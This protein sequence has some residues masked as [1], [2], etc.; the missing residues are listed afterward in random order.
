MGCSYPGF[1]SLLT[2]ELSMLGVRRHPMISLL[3]VHFILAVSYNC[4]MIQ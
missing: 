1:V 4:I 2:D 3:V